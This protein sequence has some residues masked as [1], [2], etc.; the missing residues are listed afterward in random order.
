MVRVFVTVIDELYT[1]AIQSTLKLVSLAIGKDHSRVAKNSVDT[2]TIEPAPALIDEEEFL[3]LTFKSV[4]EIFAS[5]AAPALSGVE[6]N[7]VMY[8]GTA[9]AHLYAQP[10]IEFDTALAS[11]TYGTLAIVLSQKGRWA[12]VVIGEAVGWMLREDLVDRAAYVY[13]HFVIGEKNHSDDPNTEMVRALLRDM[14]GGDVIGAPLQSGEY[15]MYRLARKD[16]TIDWP[17]TRP[18]LPGRW[19]TL[20]KGVPGVHIDVAPQQGSVMEYITEQGVGHVAYVEVVFP[21]NTISI[22]ETHFPDEG[23]Y[24]ERVLTQEEWQALKPVFIRV[25]KGR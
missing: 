21:D 2:E 14:F 7:T 10:T 11:P 24:N 19:H 25:R 22:S 13:P 9:G 15:V 6:K 4:Q 12:E 1:F 18:R 17:E 20:L 5:T 16:L 8:V 3:P 23:I